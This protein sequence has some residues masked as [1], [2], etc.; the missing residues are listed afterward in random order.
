MINKKLNKIHFERGRLVER[1]AYQRLEIRQEI[2]P[3]VNLLQRAENITNK[4]IAYTNK[5]LDFLIKYPETVIAL[6][7]LLLFK[8]PQSIFRW[9]KRGFFVWKIW[10]ALRKNLRA[11]G[12]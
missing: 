10:G 2:T 5:G 1:I 9:A 11:F 3:L 12:F 6:F 4:A 7:A 8:K